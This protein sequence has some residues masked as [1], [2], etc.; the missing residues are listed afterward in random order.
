MTTEQ[1]HTIT[2]PGL[3]GGY[4]AVAYRRLEN[5]DFYLNEQGEIVENYALTIF[6]LIVEK[7]QPR[8]VVLE[9]TEELNHYD[10]NDGWNDQWFGG[11]CLSSQA[12]I[13][14]VVEEDDMAVE[15]NELHDEYEL[16][17]YEIIGF[18][19]EMLGVLDKA[20]DLSSGEIHWEFEPNHT[21]RFSL[22]IEDL[23]QILA[24][25]KELQGAGK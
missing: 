20:S 4:R 15:F 19:G 12:R 21:Y 11:V 23:E 24:K 25:M 8:R 22:D 3:P 7:I 10:V 2:I 5:G 6:A 13:W 9:E 18:G 17:G 16:Y 14:R 1:K